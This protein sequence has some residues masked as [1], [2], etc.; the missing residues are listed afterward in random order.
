MSII[1]DLRNEI[2][3]WLFLNIAGIEIFNESI[4]ENIKITRSGLKHA[5]SYSKHFYI[6]K[7]MILYQLQEIVSKSVFRESVPDYKNRNSIK[8]IIYLETTIKVE[9]REYKIEVVVRHTYMG[10][11]YYD[12]VL[13]ST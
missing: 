12:H 13:V 2:K 10:K 7:L 8:E 9:N 4:G 3:D 6:D 11:Y 5:I 1:N